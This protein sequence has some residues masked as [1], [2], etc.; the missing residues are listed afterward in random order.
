MDGRTDGQT[1]ETH[2]I[3]LTQKSRRKKPSV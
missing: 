3:R 2:F 1:F